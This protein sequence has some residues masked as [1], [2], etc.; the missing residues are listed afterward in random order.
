M[1]TWIEMYRTKERAV[2]RRKRERERKIAHRNSNAVTADTEWRAIE[3]A[4]TQHPD[5]THPEE[6]ESESKK[7]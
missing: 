7:R 1:G 3:L 2:R 4:Q 6:R 5:S